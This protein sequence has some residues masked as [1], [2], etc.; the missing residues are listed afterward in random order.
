M[1]LLTLGPHLL[2][3]LG[4]GASGS[5]RL[6]A[7]WPV[8]GASDCTCFGNIWAGGAVL[9]LPEA[10]LAVII[11]AAVLV[12]QGAAPTLLVRGVIK[13]LLAGAPLRGVEL[14]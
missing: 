4:A 1:R 7:D 5:S 11:G 13:T 2:T 12:V 3:R 9:S 8:D 14:T 6:E 10:F